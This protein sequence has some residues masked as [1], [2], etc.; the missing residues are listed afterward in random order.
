MNQVL[1]RHHAG[2]IALRVILAA[3]T[4][5]AALLPAVAGAQIVPV[6]AVVAVPDANADAA[7]A[8]ETIV[9][10]G[11]RPIAES[12]AAALAIQKASPSLV[13]V[14]ASDAVGR[15]PDQNIAQAV[16]RL[17]GVAV[18]R[19][20]GQARYINLRGAP[21]NWTTLSFDGINVVSPE[22]RDA[23]FDSIPSAIAAQII[24]RKAVTPD[25]TGETI[26]GNVDIVT[27]SAFDYKGFHV[28]GK[29]GAGYVELGDTVEYDSSLV[30]ANR[31]DTGIGEFGVLV[32]GSYYQRGMVTDNFETDWEV[33]NEDR[34]PGAADRVW[35]RETENKLYRLTRRNYSG[36]VKLEWKPDGDTRFFVSSI[37]SAFKDDEQRS[38]YIFDL[39]DQ[40]SRLPTTATA[41]VG[42][43]TPPR[44]PNTGYADICT[45]N[46]P[47]QGT[48]Y[49]IDIASNFTIRKYKQSI[50]TNTAGG[51]HAFD[52]LKVRWRA[53]YTRSID[54]RTQP[55]QLNYDSPSAATS[56]PTVAYDLSDRQQSYVS[57]FRTTNIGGVY[58]RG[59]AV[60][61]IEDFP[62]VLSRLR[63]LLAKDT[64]KAYTGKL[65]L[66]YTAD[67]FGGETVFS[68]GG[69][70]DNRTKTS[71]EVL[72]DVAGAANFARAG[73]DTDYRGIAID[74]PFRGEIP[75][76]YDFR[77]FGRERIED[78]V[79]KARGV[80]NY[81]PQ[82][83]NYYRVGE[84]VFA[85]YAMALSKF[86]WG[87]IVGGARIEHI[88]NDGRAIVVLNGANTPIEVASEQTLVYPSLHFNFDLD[89]SKK[90]RLSF[91]TG[92]ARP[93]YDQLRPNFTFNDANL[94]VSGGNPEAKPEKA[95]GVDLYFEWY[96]QPQGF[97]SVGAF[98]KDVRDTLF[99][100]TR[101]FGLTSLNANGVDR[102]QYIFSTIVNGGDGYIYG[103]EG[104]FQQQLDPFT[105][106]LGLPDWIGGFG[107]QANATYNESKATTPDGSSI[108]F[109]G[110]S[111]FV[112]NV[113]AYYEKYGFSAR[114]NYQKRTPWIDTLGAVADGGNQYW[115][116]D[117]EL[118]ASARYA[119]TPNV[120]IYVDAANLL[121]GPGRRYAGISARTIEHETFGRRYTGGVRVNF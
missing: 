67:M 15:L 59:A 97:F 76:G 90:L 4:A 45:G 19:D 21:I 23:R 119:L 24:V 86:D 92:A 25:M 110:T 106:A 42:G 82:T 47:Y 55:A 12:Q 28:A 2:T 111:K 112:Y 105:G 9:V 62:L 66:S 63:S 49:G 22:G 33:V 102:S 79:A 84:E 56:R 78:L 16:S 101:T 91:N 87:N 71:N 99:N 14:V 115:G 13:S 44:A 80:G 60:R 107:I 11:A 48:V 51:D 95:R 50:F 116:T 118:D 72:L 69:Q 61:Q 120:E 113:G 58:G 68:F 81:V 43:A 117:D 98:Y 36:S 29:A 18:Q 38:N 39:D 35:A 5:V 32:S 54:D 73:I 26:A 27:R 40:Q 109:P 37:Y 53:N 30:L 8:A 104:A 70:Y 1:H 114:V 57:L 74:G 34:R 7:D 6:A 121:N 108:M 103:V 17:P 94:T 46:T 31:F 41:C 65:D 83:A 20:Q 85:G 93:D 75:L 3:G 64:T 77:Y 10:T 52:R 89:R 100:D 96:I 88:R